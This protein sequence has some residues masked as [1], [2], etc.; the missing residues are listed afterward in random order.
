MS[1]EWRGV[2]VGEG[3]KHQENINVFGIKSSALAILGIQNSSR[4][5]ASQL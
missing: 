1:A 2:S 3:H 4:E 5:V